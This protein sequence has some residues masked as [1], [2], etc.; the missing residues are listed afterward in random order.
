MISG[1]THWCWIF[2]MYFFG[3]VSTT[4]RSPFTPIE[5]KKRHTSLWPLS[6]KLGNSHQN[7]LC[8]RKKLLNELLILAWTVPLICIF[9]LWVS[10]PT[11]GL[12]LGNTTRWFRV[13]E[14]TPSRC[15]WDI[16]YEP[17]DLRYEQWDPPVRVRRT[18]VWVVGCPGRSHDYSQ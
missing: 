9:N 3:A 12:G 18:P 5:F 11:S 14:K 8:R 1:R 2:Q 13:W 15:P 16:C 10:A 17:R 4:I 7:N 6:P